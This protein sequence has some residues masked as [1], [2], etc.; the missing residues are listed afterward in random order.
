MDNPKISVIIPVYNVEPYL[1]RCLDSVIGQTYANL[2]ILLV[3]DGSTDGSSVVCDEYKEM[4]S[5]ILVIHKENG[6]VSSARNAGLEAATGDWIGFV[7][8]DDC[9]ETDLYEYLYGLAEKYGADVAQCAM[10]AEGKETTEVLFST[11]SGSDCYGLSSESLVSFSNSVCNKL[12]R[13]DSI[14][15]VRFGSDYPIGE[16]YLFNAEVIVRTERFVFGAEAKYRYML[17]D[18]SASHA[19]PTLRALESIRRTSLLAVER[20]R[21]KCV[22][23]ARFREELMRNN[24]DIC[25]KIV[26]FPSPEFEPLK[27]EI[28]REVRKSFREILM[29]RGLTG[30][31]RAKLCLIAW[32]WGLY[33]LLLVMS[34]KF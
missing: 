3:D 9:V 25:S 4:D 2:E 34:K 17:W 20:V 22:V 27:G 7:D 19:E 18:D 15:G 24:M 33:C 5:R 23:S 16:D 21:D 11:Q 28:R 29:M 14:E 32:W 12:Y 6:G 30:K 8:A 1:R 10:Y 13:A 31:D 26:R